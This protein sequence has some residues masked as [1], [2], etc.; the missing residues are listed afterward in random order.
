MKSNIKIVSIVAMLLIGLFCACTKDPGNYVYN[1]VNEAIVT[2]LDTAYSVNLGSNLSITPNIS[3]TLDKQMDTSNYTY[4]WLRLTLIGFNPGIPVRMASGTKINAK[5]TAPLGFYTAS[6]RVTDKKTGVYKDNFFKLL[7]TRPSYEGWL[8]L[9]GTGSGSRLDMI[10]YN[11]VQN[12]YSTIIDILKENKS[13]FK[14]LGDPSFV[15]SGNNNNGPMTTNT[16]DKIIVGASQSAA[17]LGADT[18]NYQPL[19]D[20]DN[21]MPIGY[22]GKTS[23]PTYLESSLAGSFL[24]A[25]NQAF[26]G[27]SLEFVRINLL[28]STPFIPAPFISFS[29]PTNTTQAILYS[30]DLSQFLW[31]PGS[32]GACRPLENESLFVNKTGKDLL[33]MNFVNY[34][35]GETFAILK[36]K[37]GNKVYLARFTIAKQ[38]Y[39]QEV[40]GTPMAEATNFAVSPE[41]GYVFY[42]VGSK[43]YEY[44]FNTGI[45]LEMAD[46]GRRKISLLK[47]QTTYVSGAVNARL[48]KL[49]N[50]LIVCSYDEAD[51]NASGIFDVYTV[52]GINGQIVKS[53]TYTGFGKIKSITY[54]RR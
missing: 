43:I 37:T 13:D 21:Y 40:T 16:T 17:Y 9:S 24:V 47:F 28:G 36:E 2:G 18:L 29:V 4:E 6:F 41:F 8:L 52:P 48:E 35:G 51:L 23:G 32:G 1:E 27:S 22:T 3:Y 10:S 34:N 30:K 44:D 46:Y 12:R 39:Y 7:V 54:R 5:I 33:F 20:F 45:N 53:E 31:Y 25:N 14:L 11:L 38:N 49:K 42:A 50:S 15:G 19:W 26:I